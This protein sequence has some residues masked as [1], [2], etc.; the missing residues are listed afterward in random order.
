[1]KEHQI[2]SLLI[3]Y[4]LENSPESILGSEVPFLFG[5]RRADV[6]SIQ[7]G[8]A[9]AF[10]IK[11]ANDSLEKLEY[12]IDSYKSYF[13]YCFIVCETS[14]LSQ[15]R[16]IIRKDIGIILVNTHKEIEFVRKSKQFKLH[17]KISLASTIPTD[18]LKKMSGNHSIRTKIKLCEVISKNFSL[19]SIRDSSRKYLS[20]AYYAR[21]QLFKSEIGQKITADDIITI[22]RA[23]PES[24]VKSDCGD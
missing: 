4:L 15:I 11:S 22:T 14:N 8:I 20:Q 23:T 17:D 1:M 18:I 24:Y 19:Q 13:D 16:K 9:T 5:S 10:E 6:I 21:T 2:K 12:Q 3:N 7:N